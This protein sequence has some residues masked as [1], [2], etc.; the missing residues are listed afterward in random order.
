VTVRLSESS[1]RRSFVRGNPGPWAGLVLG[2]ALGSASLLLEHTPEPLSRFS[3]IGSPWLVVAFVGGALTGRVLLGAATGS[4]VLVAAMITYYLAKPIVGSPINPPQYD[5]PL[6]WLAFAVPAGVGAGALGAVA[7]GSRRWL[8]VAA[9]S[10]MAAAIVAETWLRNFD[11]PSLVVLGMLAGAL[12]PLI[13]LR[14]W[15]DRSIGL[16]LVPAM[17]AAIWVV[18]QVLFPLVWMLR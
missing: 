16:L 4:V 10:A 17:A 7:A 13:W 15:P 18:A 9:V 8:R 14:T 6:F 11:S 2:A 5:T 12:L 3:A 1:G